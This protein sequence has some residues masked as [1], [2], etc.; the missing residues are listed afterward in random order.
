[1]NLVQ[2]CEADLHAHKPSIDNSSNAHRWFAVRIREK[3]RNVAEQ[4]L[5]AQAIE[6]FSPMT[7]ERRQWSDRQKTVSIPLF[8]GYLFCRFDP[9]FQLT[10]QRT[11]G[12]IDIVRTGQRLAEVD[13]AEL[14][15][16]DRAT[17]ADQHAEGLPH[18]VTGQSVRVVE[19]PLRG[20]TGV[21]M[22]HKSQWKLVLSVTMMNRSVAVGIDRTQVEA[23]D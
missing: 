9:E 14:E 19:G 1:M 18:L 12:V 22:E 10:I 5:K 11:L 8:S 6:F 2:G 13:P 23:V 4:M 3:F 21:L 15:A 7:T 20:M 16:V 17:R